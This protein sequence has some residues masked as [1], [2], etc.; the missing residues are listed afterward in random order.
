MKHIKIFDLTEEQI[1]YFYIFSCME[2]LDAL[3]NSQ[4]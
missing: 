3:D 4:E 1:W 2:N